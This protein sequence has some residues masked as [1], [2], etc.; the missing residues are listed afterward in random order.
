MQKRFGLFSLFAILLCVCGCDMETDAQIADRVIKRRE[1]LASLSGVEIASVSE[2]PYRTTTI[3]LK[4]GRRIMIE[5]RKHYHE[6]K[7]VSGER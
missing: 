6:L 5:S 4:D 1:E 3:F 2:E 7:V